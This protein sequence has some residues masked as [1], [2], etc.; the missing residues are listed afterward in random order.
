MSKWTDVLIWVDGLEYDPDG[1][2][3][4]DLLN[5]VLE[6]GPAGSLNR[7]VEAQ[8]L[9][10]PID[11]YLFMATTDYL[12]REEFLACFRD[13]PWYRPGTNVLTLRS[14]SDAP[15]VYRAGKFGPEG[16]LS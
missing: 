12:P 6:K 13:G 3:A 8:E 10:A 1:F 4:I 11:G 14:G 16:P 9:P 7:L 15:E 5:H 2:P